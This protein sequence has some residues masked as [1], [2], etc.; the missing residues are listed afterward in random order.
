MVGKERPSCSFVRPVRITVNLYSWWRLTAKRTRLLTWA[1]IDHI[2]L[3]PPTPGLFIS[4]HKPTNLPTGTQIIN[5]GRNRVSPELC[6]LWNI[7]LA[8]SISPFPCCQAHGHVGARTNGAACQ[9]VSAKFIKVVCRPQQARMINTSPLPSHCAIGS[10][11]FSPCQHHRPPCWATTLPSSNNNLA[12]SSMTWWRH[13]MG[14][15]HWKT[16]LCFC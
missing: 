1:S 13:F 2:R 16:F 3:P 11:W 6:G 14:K 8:S 15:I 7:S 5:R 4:Q 10:L 12:W 9:S